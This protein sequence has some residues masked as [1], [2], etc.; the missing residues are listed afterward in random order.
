MGLRALGVD[1][2][3]VLTNAGLSIDAVRDPDARLDAE[4]GLR[5]VRCAVEVSGD[6]SLGLR[7]AELYEPGSFGVVDHLAQS[8]RNLGEA[9]EVLCRYERIHQNGM[10]TTLVVDGDR[11]VVRHEVLLPHPLPPAMADNTMANLL[12]IGRRLTGID[13]TPIEA[14]FV[15]PPPSDV[16]HHARIFRC[17]LHWS[18]PHDA[19]SID[20]R[21]LDAPLRRTNR[22]LA[23]AL[24]RHAIELLAKLSVAGSL[25]DRA[26]AAISQALPRGAPSVDEI[27]ALLGMSPR[28]LQRRLRAE[29]TSHEAMLDALR[30]Q[31]AL[32]YLAR[33][34]LSSEDVAIMLG[35][36][37]S[38]GFRRAFKRWTGLSPIA[39]RSARRD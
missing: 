15:H 36:S 1:V 3:R 38:R 18:A 8:A 32:D 11:A 6:E 17:P 16:S 35:F 20:A 5:L 2:E 21:L 39:F 23:N 26:R 28:T 33:S 22:G 4:Q 24:E 7:L 13:Y 9:I 14:A 29:G 30:H 37:D 27:A 10:R 25:S 12:V 19:L 31:L 34:D